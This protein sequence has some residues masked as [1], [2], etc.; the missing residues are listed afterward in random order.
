MLPEHIELLLDSYLPHVYDEFTAENQALIEQQ[1]GVKRL[2][3]TFVEDVIL[4]V[5]AALENS[6]HTFRIA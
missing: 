6:D 2:T 1:F 5:R 4:P 3:L